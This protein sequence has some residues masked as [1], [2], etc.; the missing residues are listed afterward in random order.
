MPMIMPNV[1][2]SR[3]S[4]MNSLTMMPIQR[5]SEKFIQAKSWCV[6]VFGRSLDVVLGALHEVDEDVLEPRLRPAPLQLG[7]IPELRYRLCQ[8]GVVLPGDVQRVAERRDMR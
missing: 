3:F 1:R 6:P 8:F 5:E 2:R 7:V 4:W